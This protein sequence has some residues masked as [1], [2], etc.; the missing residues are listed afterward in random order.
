MEAKRKQH[1][2][3]YVERKELSTMNSVSGETSPQD[4]RGKDILKLS[5]LKE[6]VAGRPTLKKWLK[7]VIQRER[8]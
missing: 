4:W 5:K 1:N 6:C 2:I 7:K 8:N 3:F